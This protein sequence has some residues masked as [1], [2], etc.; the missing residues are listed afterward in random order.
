MD[1]RNENFA[2]SSRQTAGD[3]A[4]GAGNAGKNRKGLKKAHHQRIHIVHL[5]AVSLLAAGQHQDDRGSEEAQPQ[6][7]AGEGDFKKVAQQ[8]RR[9]HSGDGCDDQ[10]IDRLGQRPADHCPNVAPKDHEDRDQRADVQQRVQQDAGVVNPQ[11]GLK[12]HQMS[13]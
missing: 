3:C 13:R 1:I 11:N 6:E 7:F 4:A 5:A 12:E 9:H 2:A 10:H 8:Q